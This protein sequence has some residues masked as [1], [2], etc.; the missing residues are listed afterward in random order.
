MTA[1]SYK[2]AADHCRRVAQDDYRRIGLEAHATGA[3]LC[4][5]VID[6]LADAAPRLTPLEAEL[7]AA[8]EHAL[9]FIANTESEM[10][11]ELECGKLARAALDKARV[12]A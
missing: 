9:N 1:A 7:L 5:R 12:S 10:G 6:M 4:A 2:R 8:L 11:E 3:D